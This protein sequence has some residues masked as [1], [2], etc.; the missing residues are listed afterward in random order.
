MNP[1]MAAI[2]LT[3]LLLQAAPKKE[4]TAEE[5]LRCEPRLVFPDGASLFHFVRGL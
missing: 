5:F 2:A 3:F 4:P 1:L